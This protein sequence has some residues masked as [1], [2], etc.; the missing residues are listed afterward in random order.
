MRIRKSLLA[1][2]SSGALLA[3]SVVLATPTAYASTSQQGSGF[4]AISQTGTVTGENGAQAYGSVSGSHTIVGAA[5]T[6]DGGGYWIVTKSGHV[7][8]YGD[9][10]YYGD[11]YTDGLTGLSG[12]KPLNAPIVGIAADPSGGGY[13]LVA[14]DGGVFNFGNAPFLG[15]TYTYGV[16]GLLGAKPLNA[17]ITAIVSTSSGEGYWLIAKDGGV[18]DFGNAP[19][20]GS[21][22]TYGLTGLS[23]SK[24]LNAPIIGAIATPSG[25]GYYMVGA[26]GGVF[27]FGDAKF[28]GSTYG[29]GYTGLSGAHPLPA[30]ASSL[31]QNPNGSGYYVILGNG[32]VLAIGGAPALPNVP[33]D[34][35][36]LAIVIPPKAPQ[37]FVIQAQQPQPQPNPQ[38]QPQPQPNPQPQPQPSPTPVS[39]STTSIS[40]IAGAPVQLQASGGNGSYMWSAS[41]LPSWL[42]LSSS[43][44]LTL[45]PSTLSA[46]T[47]TIP[48]ALSLTVSG[49]GT[50]AS[51]TVGITY[52]QATLETSTFTTSTPATTS[53]T[54][55]YSVNEQLEVAQNPSGAGYSYTLTGSWPSGLYLSSSGT[56]TGTISSSVSGLGVGIRYDGTTI[57]YGT[58]AINVVELAPTITNP[59]SVSMY[60]L[61][62]VQLQATGGDGI[63]SWSD[64]STG[65]DPVMASGS[66]LVLNTANVSAS[67]MGQTYAQPITV[68]S[69]GKSTSEDIGVTLLA[70]T[71]SSSSFSS[72]SSPDIQLAVPT[73]EGNGYTF[74]ESNA[75]TI[76]PSSLT[77]SAS[78]AIAGTLSSDLNNLDVSIESSTGV[79]FATV[80][81]SITNTS[82]STVPISITEAYNWAG[83][84]DNASSASDAITSVSGTFVVP[85]LSTT[86][87]TIC[88]NTEPG[89]LCTLAEWVG[90]DGESSQQLIQAGVD[91]SPN[92]QVQPWVETITPSDAAPATYVSLETSSG[93]P[94][95]VE[96]GDT[97]SVAI[98]KNASQNWTMTLTDVTQNASYSITETFE[99]SIYGSIFGGSPGTESAEWIMESPM[100]SNISADNI[101]A[102]NPYPG[103][104]SA[105][106]NALSILPQVSAGG[107]FT[108][109]SVNSTGM[110]SEY[111]SYQDSYASNNYDLLANGDGLF[112]PTGYPSDGL[113]GAF[114]FTQS[115]TTTAGTSAAPSDATSAGSPPETF[116]G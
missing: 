108:S 87:N 92:F 52:P 9:A 60:P 37:R 103:Y 79:V 64:A 86:Q 83:M 109:A 44:Q 67:S 98:V 116:N 51:A 54:P 106:C 100:F 19:F 40:L 18:F 76:W 85:T 12:S 8:A 39:I 81:I 2:A 102:L 32:Q 23:G 35:G 33:M 20:L 27:D 62:A 24:P 48:T 114:G 61:N 90:I 69:G 45:D 110:E 25:N 30:K 49:D 13:W 43:G 94:I 96:P 80:P 115:D 58:V 14:S 78:G 22:Y 73:S 3:A 59:T 31:M 4:I 75:G 84:I 7:Y 36:K 74:A 56:I 55:E 63:Y 53:T 41:S 11:T 82:S 6:P 10:K 71:L 34:H 46:F 47:G 95:T 93:T 16:T 38:P 91:V 42:T 113:P 104:T 68:T 21:T 111:A 99:A 70:P 28:S 26:D 88:T 89:G 5:P 50:S 29:L 112:T 105:P 1:L 77:F 65:S 57:G 101:C 107:Q 15:S 97:M 66:T 17:P 72:G